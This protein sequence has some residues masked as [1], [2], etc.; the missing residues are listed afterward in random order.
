LKTDPDYQRILAAINDAAV[1][2]RS[3]KRF[4]MPGFRP[5]PYYVRQMQSYGI[6]PANLPRDAAIDVYATDRTYWQSL[7]WD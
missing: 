2:L 1:R 6:L 4:D 7:W 3:H 5:S